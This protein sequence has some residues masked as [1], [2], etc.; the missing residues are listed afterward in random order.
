MTCP[1]LPMRAVRSRVCRLRLLATPQTNS[2]Y[3]RSHHMKKI[4]TVFKRDPVDPKYVTAE[5]HPDCEWVLLGE[6][7]PTRKY[8][9]TC[10]LIDNEGRVWTRREVKPGKTAPPDW[11]EVDH[12]EV[13][14]KRVGWEPY[15]QSSFARYV[16]EA[17][18]NAGGWDE[19]G[20]TPA[21]GP[22][23]YE[24]CGPKIQ[25]NPE[26]FAEHVLIRHGR[27]VINDLDD[28]TYDGVNF[29]SLRI[30]LQAH[31][32]EGIVWHHPDGRMAKL[33]RR[34]FPTDR[35]PAKEANR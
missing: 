25:G 5:V 11:V 32:W 21:I 6:G 28:S 31:D 10:V 7:T 15:E 34:D 16:V 14:G 19:D 29:D 4:P 13:T 2:R 18:N 26:G 35:T 23:T 33:K 3:E 30:W 12:D 17:V 27:E 1:T 9:G 22:G 24:L 8:D 20:T